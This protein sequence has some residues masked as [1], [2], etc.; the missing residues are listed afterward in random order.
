MG[1]DDIF[2]RRREDRRRRKHEFKQPMSNSY[3]IVTEGKRTEP[4]YFKG[5]ERH[6]KS[7]IGGNVNVVEM[8]LIDVNGEGCSTGKLIEAA[9]RLVK[10]AK[11]HY[12]NVWLVFDKDDFKDFDEAIRIGKSRGYHIAWSNESFEYWI[13]LHF[14]YNESALHRSEWCRKLDELFRIRRLGDEKYCKNNNNLFEVLESFNGV[15]TAIKN[16][17]RRMENYD[18]KF[19]RPSEYNPGTTVYL[20][21]K[22]LKQYLD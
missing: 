2:K 17:E 3:L 12:Q 1:H 6:I 7:K 22:E 4:L 18:E 9:E 10:E 5:L 20:L 15:D 14:Q 21:V 16:A 13:Y 19:I 11:I 8:P